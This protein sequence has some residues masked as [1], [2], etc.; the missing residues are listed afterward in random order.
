[1]SETITLV[2]TLCSIIVSLICTF[3]VFHHQYNDGLVGRLGL[4]MMAIAAY[5]RV[6]N[7]ISGVNQPSNIGTL[8]WIGLAIFLLKH[9]TTFLKFKDGPNAR[10]MSK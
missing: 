6:G 1:M 9:V 3:L 2:G 7:I 10:K 5:A 8:L 4:A